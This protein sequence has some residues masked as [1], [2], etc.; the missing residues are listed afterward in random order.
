MFGMFLGSLRT[1]LPEV[2]TVLPESA[3]SKTTQEEQT[4]IRRRFSRI[5]GTHPL[6][7]GS[8]AVVTFS[9]CIAL[10]LAKR[11]RRKAV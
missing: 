10:F 8:L 1:P 3:I 4:E 2:A 11:S 6:T 5:S 9:N 7:Y